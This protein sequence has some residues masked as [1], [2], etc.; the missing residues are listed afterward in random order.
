MAAVGAGLLACGGSGDT[1]HSSGGSISLTLGS[2]S[3]SVPAGGMAQ[4]SASILRSGGYNGDVTI[5]VEGVPAGVTGTATAIETTA[6]T[7]T[8]TIVI[9]AQASTTPGSYPLTVRVMGTGISD[10][11][12][13]FTLAVTAA[14]T[15]TISL[16]AGPATVAQGDSGTVSVQV[17]RSNT[18][19]PVVLTAENLPTGVGLSFAPASV[20][21]SSSVA[22][23][24]VAGSVAAG[25]Y[26]LTVRGTAAGIADATTTIPLTVTAVAGFSLRASPSPLAVTQGDAGSTTITITP[27]GGFNGTVALSAGGLPSGVTAGFNPTSTSG[28]TSVLTLTAGAAAT[29]GSHTVTVTGSSG[30]LSAQTTL[31]LTVS[32]PTSATATLDFSACVPGSAAPPPVFFAAQDGNQPWKVIT[33]GNNVYQFPVTS[34][35]GAYA[36]VIRFANTGWVVVSYLSQAELARSVNECGGLITAT[37]SVSA[38]IA[39]LKNNDQAAFYYGGA[40]AQPFPSAGHPDVSFFPVLDGAF[41]VF[42]S[43][44]AAASPNAVR[45]FLLRNQDPPDGGSLGTLDLAGPSSFDA[46][47]AAMTVSSLLAGETTTAYSSYL[48][49]SG[50]HGGGLS[51]VASAGT[52]FSLFGVPPAQ[53]LPSDYHMFEVDGTTATS[54]RSVRLSAHALAPEQFTLPPLP[55]GV[56]VTSA[57][58]AYQRLQVMFDPPVSF[59]NPSLKLSYTDDVTGIAAYVFASSAGLGGAGN[60]F[61]MPDLSALAGWNNSYAPST[62]SPVSWQFSL[63]DVNYVTACSEGALFRSAQVSGTH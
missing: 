13:E 26:S 35:T 12:S 25:S 46:I 41:D 43:N 33:P 9:A 21:A 37:K 36:Y 56:S 15:A 42:G 29:T 14:G 28:T 2:H 7:T 27:T 50:C 19:S 63:S 30:T 54:V 16:A 17:T 10:A 51:T 62:G 61:G 32:A 38:I 24:V 5:V 48:T 52:A 45:L 55:T 6:A 47:S 23:I 3:G 60:S 53:Q 49:G 22:T 40:T 20:T 59:T 11:T 8:A 1:S 34:A 4:V 31:T 18:T 58:S 44:R 57:G 39:G